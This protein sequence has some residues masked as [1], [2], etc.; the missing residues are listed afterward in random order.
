[1]RW[2]AAELV[3]QLR[4]PGVLALSPASQALMRD[5]SD[6]IEQLRGCQGENIRLR[7]ELAERTADDHRICARELRLGQ[8]RS[9]R[10]E[11][12]RDAARKVADEIAVEREAAWDAV[13]RVRELCE[14]AIRDRDSGIGIEDIVNAIEGNQP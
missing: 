9:E 7:A 1:M 14:L 10:A 12:A 13:A 3:K 8:E 2:S 4:Y 6:M 11:A 5:A